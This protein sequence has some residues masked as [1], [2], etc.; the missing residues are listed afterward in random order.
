LHLFYIFF[1][2]LRLTIE[3]LGYNFKDFG[4]NNQ[5]LNVGL[6]CTTAH[7]K[8]ERLTTTSKA[9]FT[10]ICPTLTHV[11]GIACPRIFRIS[12]CIVK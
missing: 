3:Y 7:A 9:L 8:C 2:F 1:T 11:H 4:R 5:S 12:Y 6:Q 10:R